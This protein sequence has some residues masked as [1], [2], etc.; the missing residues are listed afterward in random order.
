[1]QAVEGGGGGEGGGGEESTKEERNAND[2]CFDYNGD[3]VNDS[4][5]MVCLELASG[6]L[7]RNISLR[8]VTL[9]GTGTGFSDMC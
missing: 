2:C 3:G 7:Q 9:E 5:V 8:V 4:D 1:M 6:N